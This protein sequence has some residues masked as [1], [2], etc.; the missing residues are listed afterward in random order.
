MKEMTSYITTKEHAR[1]MQ[2]QKKEIERLRIMVSNQKAHIA[3]NEE[4]IAELKAIRKEHLEMLDRSAEL[5]G[6]A[7]EKARQRGERMKIMRLSLG[8]AYTSDIDKY[9]GENGEPL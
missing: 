1:M 4:R 3:S 9:F 6:A 7:E 2:G 8:E 5:L